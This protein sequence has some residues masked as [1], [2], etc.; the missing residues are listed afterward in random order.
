L[1]R[2]EYSKSEKLKNTELK[3]TLVGLAAFWCSWVKFKETSRCTPKIVVSLFFCIIFLCLLRKHKYNL[4][5]RNLYFSTTFGAR[6]TNKK[7][8]GAGLL[9]L[10]ALLLFVSIPL[11]DGQTT[12]L[13]L[14]IQNAN[15][16]IGQAFGAVLSAEQAGVQIS[17]LLDQLNIAAGLLARAENSYRLGDINAATTAVDQVFPITQQVSSLSMSAESNAESATQIT[18]WLSIFVAFVGSFLFVSGLFF[19]WLLFKKRYIK[20]IL[21]AKPE[22]VND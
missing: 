5:T 19:I 7:I 18:L 21:D 1:S 11:S 20:N 4:S 15:T 14:K 3:H 16:A 9:T 2:G 22:V 10:L 8:L 17:G 12:A 13:T 6:M